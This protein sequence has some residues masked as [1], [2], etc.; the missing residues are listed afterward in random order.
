MLHLY[1]R[2]GVCCVHTVSMWFAIGV[3]VRVSLITKNMKRKKEENWQKKKTLV[4]IWHLFAFLV[5]LFLRQVMP[6]RLPTHKYN[7]RESDLTRTSNTKNVSNWNFVHMRT[8]EPRAIKST[9]YAFS[10]VRKLRTKQMR[11]SYRQ[12]I[13]LSVVNKRIRVYLCRSTIRVQRFQ[14]SSSY[15]ISHQ[16]Q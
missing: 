3:C 4:H 15:L 2:Y 9:D 8:V 16:F 7:L 11:R 5:L 6:R 12:W 13:A 10:I 1:I 14:R